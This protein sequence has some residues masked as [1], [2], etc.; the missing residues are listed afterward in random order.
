MKL[1]AGGSK[2]ITD[3]I[4]LPNRRAYD[5]AIYYEEEILAGDCSGADVAIQK[6]LAKRDIIT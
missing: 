3:I 5:N 4:S 2:S 6:Y 1:F